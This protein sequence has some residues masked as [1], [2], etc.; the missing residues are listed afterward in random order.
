MS[1]MVIAPERVPAAVGVKV[2]LIVQLAP[3]FSEPPQLLVCAKSP[4]AVMPV[5]LNGTVPLLVSVTDW[6]A[7]VVPTGWLPK[8]GLVGDN[9]AA[10]PVPV[11]DRATV[12]GLP[13]ALSV[14]V[15][16]PVREPPVVGVKVTLIVQLA[17]AATVPPQLLVWT[18]S[19]LTAMDEI[20]SVTVPLFVSVTGCAT[21]LVPTS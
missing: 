3:A 12:C 11:P 21:L 14:T 7:L 15:S 16:V 4:L 17:L 19:P 9:V 18:K 1:V 13:L 2:M 10:G 20:V 6:V 8:L 5:M